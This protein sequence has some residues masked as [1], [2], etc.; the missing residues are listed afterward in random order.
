MHSILLYLFSI[1]MKIHF[2][3]KFSFHIITIL[4]SYMIF[5]FLL[6]SFHW[7]DI[8]QFIQPIQ[9]CLLFV[10][11]MIH[12]HKH[13]CWEHTCSEILSCIHDYFP[14]VSSWK[15]NCCI[16]GHSDFHSFWHGCVNSIMSFLH[17]GTVTE[18]RTHDNCWRW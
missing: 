18:K 15:G 10:F 7:M 11:L 12:N 4:F 3:N 2:M 6:Y 5:F 16:N 13:C 14:G 9:Y 17:D 8:P 1:I